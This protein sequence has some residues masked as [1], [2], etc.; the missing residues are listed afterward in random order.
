[1]FPSC[2]SNQHNTRKV[3]QPAELEAKRKA[4]EAVQIKE[5]RKLNDEYLSMRRNNK[6]DKKS[7]E[8]SEAILSQNPEYYSVWNY[9]REILIKGLFKE[10]SKDDIQKLLEKELVFLEHILRKFPKVYWIWTHRKWCF[11]NSPNPNW[12]REMGL[13]NKMLELDPRNFHVWHYRRYVV[14]EIEKE[15]GQSLVKQEFDFTTSKINAN[16]SNFSAWHN[17]G[18][19]I[20]RLLKEN[21]DIDA[22]DIYRKELDYI[23]QAIY[24]DPDDQSSW[25][26]H[27]WLITKST[28]IVADQTVEERVAILQGEIDSIKELYEVEPESKWCIYSLVFYQTFLSELRGASLKGGELED[29]IAKL[30]KLIEIDPGRSARYNYL[31]QRII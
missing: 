29:V 11:K 21:S 24:T 17:R 3:K 26:Y 20:P 16:F 7:F 28:D 25:I 4:K 30:D 13:I 2:T 27:E 1:L 9:R 22:R 23:R 19:L 18:K 6:Y 8:L 5:Y 12:T 31:K 15:K 10:M 14:A